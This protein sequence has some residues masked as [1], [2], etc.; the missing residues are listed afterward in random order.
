MPPENGRLQRLQAGSSR[1]PLVYLMA[2][3]ALGRMPISGHSLEPAIDP[4][5]TLHLPHD[6]KAAVQ[7]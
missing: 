2:I 3:R 1:L 5:Q 4:M 7:C 6:R